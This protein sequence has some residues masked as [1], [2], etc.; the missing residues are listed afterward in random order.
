MNAANQAQID[1]VIESWTK[2]YVASVGKHGA[3]L[4][5]GQRQ[6]IGVARALY[7]HANLIIFHEAP[8][9]INLEA[10]TAVIE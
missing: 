5:G 3:R 6:R 10:E 2:R 9:S 4:F 1:V 8:S 7:R